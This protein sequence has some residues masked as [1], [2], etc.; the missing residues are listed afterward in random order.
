[1]ENKGIKIVGEKGTLLWESKG[2][3]P[4]VVSVNL[5]GKK[6]VIKSYI[7]KHK[8]NSDNIYGEM[9]RD[10]IYYRRNTQSVNEALE[11]LD[12]ALKARSYK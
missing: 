3:K 9:L 8:L 7:N 4:E 11:V 2:R 5:Y 10:F 6:S 1:M 12:I